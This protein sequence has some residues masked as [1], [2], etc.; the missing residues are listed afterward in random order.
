M[1][2]RRY[3]LAL[4]CRCDEQRGDVY[5]VG[6]YSGYDTADNACRGC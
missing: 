6:I 3:A 1:E 5:R 4:V 2:Q